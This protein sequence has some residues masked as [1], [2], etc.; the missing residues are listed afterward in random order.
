MLFHSEN[1][2][3]SRT[4]PVEDEGDRL[5]KTASWRAN[6]G[7]AISRK[8]PAQANPAHDRDA[9]A[10]G[11]VAPPGSPAVDEEE[12][13]QRDP[14]QDPVG[15]G[16]RCQCD[17]RPRNGEA[18]AVAP[19][20]ASAQPERA[21]HQRL[22]EPEVVGLRHERR[23]EDRD[24]RQQAG[25][26]RDPLACPGVARERPRHR[27]G[28]RAQQDERQRGCQRRR[29]QEPD[30][31]HLDDRGQRH[32][33]RVGRD[34]EDRVGGDLPPDLHEDPDE[35][36]VESVSRGQAAGDVHVVVRVRV[37]GIGEMQ[38]QE[39]PDRDG[40]HEQQEVASARWCTVAPGRPG[41]GPV[42]MG[43]RCPVGVE[44]TPSTAGLE[45]CGSGPRLQAARRASGTD[46]SKTGISA[47][48]TAVLFHQRA[49]TANQLPTTSVQ[50]R[51][52][53]AAPCDQH[54][55]DR[56]SER[57]W[58]VDPVRGS[59]RRQDQA[60]PISPLARPQ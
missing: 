58:D 11:A 15:A 23:R 36:D 8:S 6:H 34:G 55:G 1:V 12:Q 35:V 48:S 3:I 52:V 18:S 9:G 57:K 16:E 28:E 41:A 26:E 7:P 60:N 5:P 43:Y 30:E 47:T 56:E 25:A 59:Q 19:Q 42:R 33:V 21:D 53:L 40:E 31:G 14:D 27:R 20:P 2:R 13:P 32:P 37:C 29:S 39:R 24:R 49:G 22:V 46:W 51:F 54:C 4:L 44:T 38:E 10:P 50:R 17:Q 45:P